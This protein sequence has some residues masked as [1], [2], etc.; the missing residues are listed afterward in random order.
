VVT[1]H[2]YPPDVRALAPAIFQVARGILEAEASPTGVYPSEPVESPLLEAT[3]AYMNVISGAELDS[4][5]T[6]VFRILVA[7]ELDRGVHRV[8]RKLSADPA[9]S[10]T[11][12]DGVVAIAEGLG[13][14]PVL[15][16][17]AL[18]SGSQLVSR[19]L[20]QLLEPTA[21]ALAQHVVV[22]QRVIDYMLT[23]ESP[24]PAPPFVAEPAMPT[25]QLCPVPMRGHAANIDTAA[26]L[27]RLL[28]GL[29]GRSPIW[30]AGAPGSG[31]RTLLAAV[32]AELGKRLICVSQASLV[33]SSIGSAVATMWRELLLGDGIL[34]V[35]DAEPLTDTSGPD[36]AVRTTAIN[37]SLV[38][39]VDALVSA[40]L[41]VVF[42]SSHAPPV[43]AFDQPIQVIQ[44]DHV[45]REDALALWKRGLPN[46]PEIPD[47]AT[48]FRLP[49]GRIVRAIGAAR[50]QAAAQHGGPV[51]A[52]DV[53]RAISLGVAQQ[54][55]ILGTLVQDTQSW[56]DIVLPAET[57]ES[58][59]EMVSRVR[60]RH[61]VLDEWGFRGKLSKGLGVAA[62]FH[63]PPGTGKTMV[64]SLIAR[65]LGQDLYQVDLSRMVSK[66]IGETEK[67]LAK[68][69]DAA[70]GANV[71]LLFDEA[72]ALFSKRT[73]V[74]SSN[75]RHANAEINYLLQRVERFEGVC[76]LTT[77]FERSIDAAFK[78]RLAFRIEFPMPDA[79][80]RTELWRR[81]MPSAANVAG[82][83]DYA[84]L[85]KSYE[86]AGGNIRNAL[87]RAAFIAADRNEPI[88]MATL[89][90]AVKLEYRD[91]GK[92]GTSGTIS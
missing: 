23:G 90:R 87:L 46:V 50:A 56:S 49:P 11:P 35:H 38:H 28:S 27:R 32:A 57:L 8:L 43:H 62:L 39:L 7:A 42:A 22:P 74:S 58:V 25:A 83:V 59:Q 77:N 67:N 24:V 61:R 4:A 26:H 30:I 37:Q 55:S 12:V 88:T 2:S 81:M 71:M 29:D 65:E 44:L 53:T 92:L 84:S 33:S 78:R 18:W 20:V 1:G 82:D 48:R 40:R 73:E 13:E 91:A 21:P 47:L 41:P 79:T 72:D 86:L 9:T 89:Q 75:D 10:G 19:G 80:E 63:G 68:V 52:Q 16:L 76:I 31:R 69:F 5:A 3:H 60:Q 14:D 70:E 36:Q 45:R 15:A 66:W 54:V 34:C 64:A 85:A 17:R 51:T 6:L